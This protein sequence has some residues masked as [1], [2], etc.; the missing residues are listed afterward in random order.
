LCGGATDDVGWPQATAIAPTFTQHNTAACSD[1]DAVCQACAALT[2][3]ETFQAL[4]RRLGLPI[5]VTTKDGRPWVQAGWHCYSH[6]VSEDGHYEAPHPAR[7]REVLLDPPAGRW[8]L[9]INT[10]GQ[11]HTLFRAVIASSRDY[12]PVQFDEERVWITRADFV[13]C[14]AAW[15]YLAALG[16][17]KD[18][19]ETG[20]YHPA[21]TM[22]AGLAAWWPAEA[23]MAPWR[24]DPA[25]VSVIR[26]VA[27]SAKT[28]AEAGEAIMRAPKTA[29]AAASAQSL[30]Q[31][32]LF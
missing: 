1:S 22:R 6:L 12:F 30:A 13:A 26:H 32:L 5:K 28:I 17:G 25:L 19:I 8:V 3:A 11:K 29:P 7:M 2:R 16:C 31:G 23:A 20:R 9:T 18:G 21:D 4:V 27:R 10:S 24:A 15:E 14:L